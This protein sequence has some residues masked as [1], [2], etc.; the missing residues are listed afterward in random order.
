VSLLAEKGKKKRK[1]EE[2]GRFSIV[3]ERGKGKKF[4]TFFGK[5]KGKRKGQT[6]AAP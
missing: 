4:P 1:K 3:A 6:A 5:P 2:E